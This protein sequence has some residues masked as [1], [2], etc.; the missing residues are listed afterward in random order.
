MKSIIQF[1]DNNNIS[2]EAVELP[3]LRLSE[4]LGH[5]FSLIDL[6]FGIDEKGVASVY[7]DIH[8]V[9]MY[10]TEKGFTVFQWVIRKGDSL[11]ASQ[12]GVRFETNVLNIENDI[13]GV[14]T[15]LRKDGEVYHQCFTPRSYL[16]EV[17]KMSTKKD[18]WEQWEET[19]MLSS[20]LKNTVRSSL[21][22][23]LVKPL[24][25]VKAK[26]TESNTEVNTE[27]ST[28]SPYNTITA[29]EIVDL[30]ESDRK[31][32]S[33]ATGETH[34]STGKTPFD[35]DK[36]NETTVDKDPIDET[37]I[38]ENQDDKVTIDE[39]TVNEDNSDETT[40][41]ENVEIIH[42]KEDL[43][44]K[45]AEATSDAIIET[46]VEVVSKEN[47]VD[48]GAESNN[49][50][51][52]INAVET[53]DIAGLIALSLASPKKSKKRNISVKDWESRRDNLQDRLLKKGEVRRREVTDVTELRDRRTQGND[54]NV[55]TDE[56]LAKLNMD[57]K[58]IDQEAEAIVETE[59]SS[60]KEVSVP[61]NNNDD[62]SKVQKWLEFQAEIIQEHKDG[63]FGPGIQLRADGI[64]KMR[65]TELNSSVIET[66]DFTKEW[67]SEPSI[68]KE[69]SEWLDRKK[70][71]EKKWS[72]GAEIS[73]ED[74][75]ELEKTRPDSV[76]A[77]I[78]IPINKDPE[79]AYEPE[80]PPQNENIMAEKVRKNKFDKSHPIDIPV[81]FKRKDIGIL[82]GKIQA[83]HKAGDFGGHLRKLASDLLKQS[84]VVLPKGY[85]E[86]ERMLSPFTEGN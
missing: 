35:E 10:L 27:E 85:I 1:M 5:K 53:N 64:L 28:E 44:E 52:D 16:D 34:D 18:S 4:S 70:D 73:N 13:I 57:E 2:I 72:Q 86:P 59:A 51:K 62:V 23:I 19:M 55:F 68:P 49:K 20:S 39:T 29:D 50:E 66:V 21:M 56:F 37:P 78:N 38:N 9:K 80:N 65:P 12:M 48:V 58:N 60:P 6:N 82:V 43:T 33:I 14:G 84:P 26:F 32:K 31:E 54:Q 81:K 40:F 76:K 15:V 47:G 3:L 83:R 63:N 25:E 8:A 7:I 36:T 77:Q 79:P 22:S 17:K 74:I 71:L 45:Q 24:V 69:A 30:M 42:F 46:V 61:E 75:Y 11:D 41:G 67:N